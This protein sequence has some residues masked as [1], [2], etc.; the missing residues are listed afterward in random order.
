MLYKKRTFIPLQHRPLVPG[1]YIANV[2]SERSLANSDRKK[3]K[4]SSIVVISAQEDIVA[5]SFLKEL[6]NLNSMI[7][8]LYCDNLGIS[9]DFSYHNGDLVFITENGLIEP[10]AIYHRNSGVPLDHDCREKH[11]S[12]FEVLDMWNGV[13]LGQ[14]GDNFHNA[15]KMY[16]TIASLVK[17]RELVNCN[18][19]VSFPRSFF[20][21]GSFSRLRECFKGSLI[22]KSCS[23]IRSKV[24]TDE[25]FQ[26]WDFKNL[27]FLPTLFQEKIEGKDIRVH[28]CQKA[29]WPLS[30]T[31]K[32]CIDYRYSSR[33]F[34]SYKKIRF[35]KKLRAFCEAIADIEKNKLI[36][37]DF[38]ESGSK[39]F[40]LESNPGPGWSTFNHKS[41]KEFAKNIFNFLNGEL[42]YE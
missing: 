31:G 14:R 5:K 18:K 2:V 26:H 24:A 20:L 27:F 21:K 12:F 39:L 35:T 28:L 33:G 42:S 36:G 29:I 40:C 34:V 1:T 37:V 25:E 32:D 22:V 6:E 10:K 3:C 19:E 23:G 17:A 30:I 38:I 7:C 13:S 41:K 15:S 8:H 11:D 16:Q 9:W 4:I